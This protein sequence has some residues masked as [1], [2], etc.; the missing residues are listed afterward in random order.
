[1]VCAFLFLVEGLILDLIFKTSRITVPPSFYCAE[2]EMIAF[3]KSLL[4]LVASEEQGTSGWLVHR[5]AN[6]K[7]H[8]SLQKC[9]WGY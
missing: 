7:F 9:Y 8:T 2:F 5:P 4:Y 3:G 1:M 6:S